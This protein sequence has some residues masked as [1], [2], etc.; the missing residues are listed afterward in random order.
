VNVSRVF[1]KFRCIHKKLKEFII[2]RH[3][4]KALAMSFAERSVSL[5]G[6]LITGNVG[7]IQGCSLL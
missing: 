3:V 2:I 5:Q 4:K 6:E 1:E 7:D